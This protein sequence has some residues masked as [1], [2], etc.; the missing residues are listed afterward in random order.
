MDTMTCSECKKTVMNGNE[1]ITSYFI[2]EDRRKKA[3]EAV[4]C[5]DCDKL[6]KIAVRALKIRY[7]LISVKYKPSK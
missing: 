7:R 4:L 6:D 2:Y 5:I 1:I 3:N